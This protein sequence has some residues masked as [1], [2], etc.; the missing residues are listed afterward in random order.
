MMITQNQYKA[1]LSP[2]VDWYAQ[3]G[4]ITE[5]ITRRI[6]S[7]QMKPLVI[8]SRY[9]WYNSWGNVQAIGYPFTR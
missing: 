4:G 7:P 5:T 6:V 8:L 2:W 1:H 3:I 9:Q